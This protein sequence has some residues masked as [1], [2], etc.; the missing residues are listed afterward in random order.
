M[1]VAEGVEIN[2]GPRR[3]VMLGEY[4]SLGMWRRSKT[5]K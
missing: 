1:A 2:Q 5:K 4:G 3:A